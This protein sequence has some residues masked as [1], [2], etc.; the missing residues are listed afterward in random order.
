MASRIKVIKSLKELGIKPKHKKYGEYVTQF[1]MNTFK[2]DSDV[3]E[4]NENR[5]GV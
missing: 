2:V 4:K 1:L 5:Q 3:S